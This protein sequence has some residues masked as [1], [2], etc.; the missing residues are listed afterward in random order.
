MVEKR[1]EL[2]PMQIDAVPGSLPIGELINRKTGGT[3]FSLPCRNPQR[4]L[5]AEDQFSS[6]NLRIS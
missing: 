5:L 4:T 3:P 6:F 2:L 1:A